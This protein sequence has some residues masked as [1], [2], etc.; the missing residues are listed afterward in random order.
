M[1]LDIAGR[2]PHVVPPLAAR[3]RRRRSHLAHLANDLKRLR[4]DRLLLAR[5]RSGARSQVGFK[6]WQVHRLLILVCLGIVPSTFNVGGASIN[7]LLWIV[8]AVAGTILLFVAPINPRAWPW[9]AAYAGYFGV[10]LLSLTYVQQVAFGVQTLVQLSVPAVIYLLAWSSPLAPRLLRAVPI[11]GF[12]GLLGASVLLVLPSTG[13]VSIAVRPLAIGLAPLFAMAT[14][15]NTST[16]YGVIAGALAVTSAT[17]SGS[18][19]ASVVLLLLV[20]TSPG[21]RLRWKGRTVFI[22]IMVACV[23]LYAQTTAFKK[24]FFFSDTASLSTIASNS[25]LLN[26][27]GRTN[28]WPLI[29]A[30]CNVHPIRGFGVGA[31]YGI[32]SEVSNGAFAQP[33]NEFIRGY[34]DTGYVG[35][36]PLWFYY[37]VLLARSLWLAFR[38]PRRRRLHIAGVQA[39]A[40]VIIFAFTDNPL[41]YTGVVMAPTLLLLGLSHSAGDRLPLK[42]RDS[43]PTAG[44]GKDLRLWSRLLPGRRHMSQVS[45][46]RDPVSR[47]FRC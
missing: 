20:I 11:I 27:S 36:V 45:R 8:Y 41:V 24:R 31:A 47:R 15:D 23:L 30:R 19:S 12:V 6:A 16:L 39:I 29:E 35:S 7:A 37:A 43:L 21:I 4:S 28:V 17:V 5:S 26:T 14:L 2:P 10:A 38:D 3:Q 44:S 9:V 13:G 22:A 42:E 1:S 18:R 46:F 40:A 32:S 25:S 34:C 33:H